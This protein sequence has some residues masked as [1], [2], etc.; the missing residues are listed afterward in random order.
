MD[1]SLVDQWRVALGFLEEDMR[2][3]RAEAAERDQV[4]AE[5]YGHVQRLERE[6]KTLKERS[7]EDGNPGIIDLDREDRR[8]PLSG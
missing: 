8:V 3:L 6:L 5:L 4:I 7:G 1:E 2:R